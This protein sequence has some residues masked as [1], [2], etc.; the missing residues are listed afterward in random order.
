MFPPSPPTALVTGAARRLGAAMVERLATEGFRVVLH[1]NGSGEEAL[2]L[3]ARLKA[4]GASCETVQG[5][6]LHDGEVRRI[7]AEAR[8]HFGPIS[9]LVNNASLFRN[10]DL[11]GAEDATLDAH[12]AVNLKAPVRLTEL[13]ASQADL[14]ERALVVNMLDN[15]IFALNP[16]FYTYT[17]SKSALHTA[18][19][20]GAMRL[21]GRPRICG[22]APSITLI[23]G[24]QTEAN[25]QK[26][27]RINPLGRRAFPDDICEA[28]MT[29]W[30]DP[31]MNGEVLSVD[32]GQALWRLERDVAFLVKVGAVDG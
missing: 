9:L 13:L 17:L 21:K 3:A 24:K 16:D 19:T 10:D 2:A 1:Y 20:I 5:D 7:W 18:T 32:G 26:S 23:S 27:A 6:L 25:F 14:P 4:E 31:A 30:R 29:L 15:K 12:M 11:F 22:I 8:S 28:L